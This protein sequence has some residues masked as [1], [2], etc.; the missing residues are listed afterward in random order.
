MKKVI[1]TIARQ[2]CS[3]GLKVGKRLAEELGINCYDSEMFRLVSDDKAMHDSHV[4]H[5]ARIKDTSLYDVA[6]ETFS[7]HE[8]EEFREKDEM[9]LMKNLFSY[10]SDIIRRLAD[11]ESCVIVGRCANDILAD[12]DD[13]V[14]V[15]LWAPMEFRLKRASSIKNM[16]EEELEGYIRGVDERRASYYHNYTGGDWL[17]VTNYEL[18]LDVS[19]YGIRGSAELIRKYLEMRFPDEQTDGFC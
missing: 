14:S 19:R 12:R 6:Q 16:P 5:D 3:G 9:L 18:S 15:F 2:H 7:E 4:A 10:Q 1:I 17:D 11:Q 13:T 8:D